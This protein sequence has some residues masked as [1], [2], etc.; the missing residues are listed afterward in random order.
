[1]SIVSK[2]SPKRVRSNT[3]LHA[4]PMIPNPMSIKIVMMVM[5]EILYWTNLE[6]ILFPKEPLKSTFP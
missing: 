1:M 3:A 2:T 5:P 6:M 4:R